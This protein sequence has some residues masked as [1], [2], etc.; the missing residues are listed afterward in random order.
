MPAKVQNDKVTRLFGSTGTVPVYIHGDGVNTLTSLNWI[1]AFEEREL[2]RHSEISG[3]TSIVTYI[4]AY[5]DGVMPATQDELNSILE[6][7]PAETKKKYI[8]GSTDAVVVFN[9]ADLEMSQRSVLKEQIINDIE[10]DQ[11]PTGLSATPSGNFDLFTR[12]IGALTESKEQ[13]TA[14]GF[15]LVFLFLVGV[16]GRSMQSPLL[17]PSSS[18]SGGMPSQCTCLV[19]ITLRLLQPS[20]Q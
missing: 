11:L 6:R 19:L 12:L 20:G 10:F 17:S 9:I 5:N 1:N 3:S 15:I 13:M 18:S 16:Y 14:L 2:V 8:S 7:I 4:L